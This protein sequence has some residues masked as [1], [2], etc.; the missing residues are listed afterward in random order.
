MHKKTCHWGGNGLEMGNIRATLEPKDKFMNNQLVIRFLRGPNTKN[1]RGQDGGGV[2]PD[3][4]KKTNLQKVGV[5]PYKN[6]G[7][8]VKA[9]GKWP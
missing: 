3:L 1:G 9:R 7:N 5:L 2:P 4:Q 6:K 8:V